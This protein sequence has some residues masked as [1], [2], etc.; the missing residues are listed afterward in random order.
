MAD[1]I[2]V[3]RTDEIVERIRRE[4]D[5]VYSRAAKE[6]QEKADKYFS[7]FA[8][9]D[10]K[11]QE[12][13]KRGELSE[14]DYLEWRRN[15]M[16][17]G[18][19]YAEL[20][21]T[22]ST[23]FA[24]ADKI[25]SSIIGGYMPEAYALNH[26][27]A[28]YEIEHD[29]SLDTSYTLYNRDT[30]QR[31]IRDEDIQLKPPSPNIPE[32]KRWNRQHIKSELAQAVL[33]GE[34]ISKISDRLRR[35]T[36]MDRSAAMR[37]A[38]TAITATQNRGRLD[39][40]IRARNMG[41]NL[42]KEWVASHDG[43]TRESHAEVDGEVVELD[44]NF[45]NGLECPGDPGGPPEEIYNCRCAMKSVLADYDFKNATDYT[46]YNSELPDMSYDEWIEAHEGDSENESLDE[47][48]PVNGVDLTDTWQRRPDQFQYEIE[49]IINAQGFDGLPRVVS[50]EEFDKAVDESNLI[51][52]R[53]YTAP[54]AEVLESYKDS[55]Y[56]GEWYVDCSHGGAKYGRGMYS[57][58]T[59]GKKM[60][61][62][63]SSIAES[64]GGN[65]S[66]KAGRVETFTM[67]SDSR[68]ISYNDLLKEQEK[69]N[70]TQKYS[71]L[72][73]AYSQS[74]EEKAYI[75]YN[76]GGR[77]LLSDEQQ[78]M[79]E[80]FESTVT[81]KRYY[82]LESITDTIRDTRIGTSEYA[83]MKG[84]DAVKVE[85]EGYAVILN[86]TKCIFLGE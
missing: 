45:S 70:S 5:A 69:W 2:A 11:K 86:R 19:R 76:S 62:E 83:A 49:D 32:D 39:G 54:N 17:T 23:D 25:S 36:D 64:Y 71:D 47:R 80:N 58:Y 60:T 57:A 8:K 67:T 33:Q 78:K 41:I 14:K 48:H 85:D 81:E 73:T 61:D 7:G 82:E 15:K 46:E 3:Q 74:E 31:L 1:D 4:V 16:L 55:L 42:K 28:T 51:C 40:F 65:D 56:N 52:V 30:V 26:N 13:V 59:D 35:V 37:N 44:E 27:Y 50:R 72:A 68:I 10:G 9:E 34:S 22:L 12:Q 38:R 29:S 20:V 21:N 6:A 18:Q 43:L 79:A 84:Y 75:V 77:R 53:G 66:R 63:M 24:N